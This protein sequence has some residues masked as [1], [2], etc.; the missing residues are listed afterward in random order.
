M[1]YLEEE[2]FN[3]IGSN[4]NFDRDQT[5]VNTQSV[6]FNAVQPLPPRPVVQTTTTRRVT[7]PAPT[8]QRPT[9]P[10]PPPTTTTQRV[11]RPPTTTTQRQTTTVSTLDSNPSFFPS[12]TPKPSISKI[13]F[14]K[15]FNFTGTSYKKSNY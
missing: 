11:T 14:K 12:Y 9:R 5:Q 13:T 4:D 6:S 7:R 10:P 8:T 1:E 3:H 15:P 2:K